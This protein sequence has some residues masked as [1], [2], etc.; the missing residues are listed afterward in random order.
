MESGSKS[1]R[2]SFSQIS[3]SLACFAAELA[4]L[5]QKA[6]GPIPSRRSE[7][8]RYSATFEAIS[9]SLL[10]ISSRL[11]RNTNTLSD[12]SNG[13]S[14][15]PFI[16]ELLTCHA[17]FYPFYEI[18]LDIIQHS[19]SETQKLWIPLISS[20]TRD[21]AT[22]DPFNAARYV[23]MK[24]FIEYLEISVAR[25]VTAVASICESVDKNGTST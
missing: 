16:R 4:I 1:F 5:L 13:F 17:M 25:I 7:L 9:K 18:Y 6:S 20:F 11:R 2:P 19:G 12:L 14:C 24:H 15:E 10:Q 21:K 8:E 3:V 22:S 23:N